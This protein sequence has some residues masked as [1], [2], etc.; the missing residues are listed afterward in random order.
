MILKR[1]TVAIVEKDYATR[2]MYQREL[3]QSYDV[4][5]C[6]T[7]VEIWQTLSL[8]EIDVIVLEPVGLVCDRWELLQGIRVSSR[9]LNIRII[10]SSIMEELD[11][12]FKKELA[13]CLT[14]PVLP[15]ALV[16]VIQAV[17]QTPL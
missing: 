15:S 3:E 9:N 14:K 11:G 16:L 7:E 17:L 6:A 13:A 4:F 10:L 8:H 1:P 5:P 12:D 2:E